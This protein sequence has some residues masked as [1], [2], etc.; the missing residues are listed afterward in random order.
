ME[1][2]TSRR[3]ESIFTKTLCASCQKKIKMSDVAGV[4]LTGWR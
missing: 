2:E 4:N 3:K 1:T